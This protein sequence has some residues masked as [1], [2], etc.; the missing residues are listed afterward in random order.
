M[1]QLFNRCRDR[2]LEQE[3][4]LIWSV[5]TTITLV[6]HAQIATSFLHMRNSTVRQKILTSLVVCYISFPKLKIEYL[7][8][9]KEPDPRE[10]RYPTPVIL[11]KDWGPC[12]P[13][14]CRT[15]VESHPPLTM[16]TSSNLK[17]ANQIPTC[18]YF[19][20]VEHS[21][22]HLKWLREKANQAKQRKSVLVGNGGTDIFLEL[23]VYPK[24]CI[25]EG[26]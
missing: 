9:R 3:A 25:T 5:S 1:V 17:T 2:R 14:H 19:F 18:I 15:D 12:S 4:V 10:S 24:R 16:K 21:S 7:P 22:E 6:S 13:F 23:A 11:A 26:K 20:H 8:S